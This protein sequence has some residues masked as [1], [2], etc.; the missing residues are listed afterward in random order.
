MSKQALVRGTLMAHA[1]WVREAGDAS[2]MRL[3]PIEVALPGPGEV[4]IQQ[5]AI[6]LNAV[7]VM[8]RDGR[9]PVPLPTVIG[10]EGVGVIESIAEGVEGYRIGDRVA[11]FF[12][13]GAYATHRVVPISALIRLPDSLTNRRAAAFLAKGLTAWMGIRALHHL[14]PGE[15]ILI[16][17]ASGSV[18]SLLSRWARSLGVT[19]VG[20]AGSAEKMSQVAAGASVALLNGEP[21][22]SAKVRAIAS[23]GVDV[24]YE[25]VGNATFESS[26]EAVK[27]GGTIVSIGAASGPPQV[28]Q[29][30]LARR[31]IHLKSGGT[32]E[33]VNS[34]TVQ[35]A[36]SELFDVIQTGVF[37]DLN[38]V[39]YPLADAETAHRDL[40]CRRVQGLPILLP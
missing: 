22:F 2:V 26:I 4:R 21:G 18:G 11:Y 1:I 31:G 14:S 16:Q 32:P 39:S 40:E 17:G 30:L 10:F 15:T 7:D 34:S 19:V 25:M 28:D 27:Q 13:P 35:Q 38:I 20:V 36:S 33:Y 23:H 29:A 37:D 8:V 3:E 9:F 6:G 5:E 24:V 12:S